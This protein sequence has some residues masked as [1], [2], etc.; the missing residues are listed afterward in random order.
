MFNASRSA[1]PARQPNRPDAGPLPA[2]DS[3]GRAAGMVLDRVVLDRG[4][5]SVF[6]GL[7]LTLSERRIGLV[8]DNGSGKSTLLRLSLIHI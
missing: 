6:A 3:P 4:A 5:R 7:S 8:G 1:R 2:A